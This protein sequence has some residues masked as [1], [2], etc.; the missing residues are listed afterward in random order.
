MIGLGKECEMISLRNPRADL[1][2]SRLLEGRKTRRVV[3]SSVCILAD[4]ESAMCDR[5]STLFACERRRECTMEF[6]YDA[7]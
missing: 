5:E 6:E 1:T 7:S 2:I 3:R 4:I